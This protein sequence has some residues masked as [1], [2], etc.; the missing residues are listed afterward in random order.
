VGKWEGVKVRRYE[1]WKVGRYES[2][3]V[4]K[5]VICGGVAGKM[6]CVWT[7]FRSLGA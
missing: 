5:R 1:G 2:G 7:V 4:G 6:R 3:K